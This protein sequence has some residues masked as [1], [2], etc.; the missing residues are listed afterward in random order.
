[1][2]IRKRGKENWEL[3][4]DQ[5]GRVIAGG[6]ATKELAEAGLAEMRNRTTV[7]NTTQTLDSHVKRGPGRPR[8]NG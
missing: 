7:A 4:D 3:Y 1:M 6:Y 5:T 8:K 2:E